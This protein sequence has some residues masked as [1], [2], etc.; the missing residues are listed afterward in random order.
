M[1][2]LA[3]MISSTKYWIREVNC[4]WMGVKRIRWGG[5]NAAIEPPTSARIQ[6]FRVKGV[7]QRHSRCR[8]TYKSQTNS[9]FHRGGHLE[10]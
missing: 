4:R 10:T 1:M 2:F 7:G 3:A 5:A 9:R 6:E 8:R